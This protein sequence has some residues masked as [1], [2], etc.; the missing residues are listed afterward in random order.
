MLFPHN[1][2]STPGRCGEYCAL[3][4]GV[5]ARTR[6]TTKSHVRVKIL[7]QE[8][9]HAHTSQNIRMR[10]ASDQCLVH[11]GGSANM[12]EGSR[13]GRNSLATVPYSGST[14]GICNCF[15]GVRL[16]VSRC[17]L[18]PRCRSCCYWALVSFKAVPLHRINKR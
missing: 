16:L 7:R 6:P 3:G 1:E 10:G 14:T 9:S 8:V 13:S 12:E 17:C 5:N 2:W 18:V 15:A 11:Y 4:G